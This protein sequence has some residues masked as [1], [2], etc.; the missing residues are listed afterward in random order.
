MIISFDVSVSSPNKEERLYWIGVLWKLIDEF[1]PNRPGLTNKDFH[2]WLYNTWKIE[3]IVSD[4]NPDA[5]TGVS[6]DDSSVSMLLLKYPL[7]KLSD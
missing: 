7:R 6:I 4:S 1:D 5:L 3:I 2:V